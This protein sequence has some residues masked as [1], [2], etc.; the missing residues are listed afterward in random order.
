MGPA[1]EIPEF[2][3]IGAERGGE[4]ETKDVGGKKEKGGEEEEEREVKAPQVATEPAGSSKK[5]RRRK[6]RK[7]SSAGKGAVPLG[8]LKGPLKGTGGNSK[9]VPF[10]PVTRPPFQPNNEMLSNQE[11]A[12]G[13][14]GNKF[15]VNL[16]TTKER[17]L[18][19]RELT[20]TSDRGRWGQL[21][22]LQNLRKA[23]IVEVAATS[24]KISWDPTPLRPFKTCSYRICM[25]IGWKNGFTPV[26]EDTEKPFTTYCGVNLKPDTRYTFH[27]ASLCQSP[28]DSKFL[29]ARLCIPKS[30][31]RTKEVRTL[32]Q[33]Y[34]AAW[35]FEDEKEATREWRSY[36]GEYKMDHE[37]NDFKNAINKFVEVG[38]TDERCWS[39]LRCL[40]LTFPGV[41]PGETIQGGTAV[42]VELKE[43]RLFIFRAR[44]FHGWKVKE[45]D[46]VT[47]TIVRGEKGGIRDLFREAKKGFGRWREKRIEEAQVRGRELVEQVER[48]EVRLQGGKI[49]EQE[50]AIKM[51]LE[52]GEEGEEGNAPVDRGEGVYVKTEVTEPVD[53]DEPIIISTTTRYKSKPPTSRASLGVWDKKNTRVWS[54]EE[55]ESNVPLNKWHTISCKMVG[56]ATARGKIYVHVP[57][58][59][60]G[61]LFIDDVEV[62]WGGPTETERLVDRVVEACKIGHLEHSEMIRIGLCDGRDLSAVDWGGSSDPFAVVRVGEGRLEK[63][64]EREVL[65][66]SV[67]YANLFP[68]WNCNLISLAKPP[69]PPEVS[70]IDRRESEINKTDEAYKKQVDHALEWERKR[71]NEL[72][73][74][75]ASLREANKTASKEKKEIMDNFRSEA[76]NAELKADKKDPDKFYVKIVIYDHDL[77]GDDDYMGEVMITKR[78]LF[79]SAKHSHKVYFP[80]TGEIGEGRQ[81]RKATGKVAVIVRLHEWHDEGSRYGGIVKALME[82]SGKQRDKAIH[83]LMQTLN[84]EV[85]LKAE[86][87]RLIDVMQEPIVE[88]LVCHISD[89]R[90]CEGACLALMGLLGKKGPRMRKTWGFVLRRALQE[91]ILSVGGADACAEGVLAWDTGSS[92]LRRKA[93]CLELLGGLLDDNKSVCLDTV[94]RNPR[95][96]IAAVAGLQ[97]IEKEADLEGG[98]GDFDDDVQCARIAMAS[99]KLMMDIQYEDQLDDDV[100][101][102]LWRIRRHI[103]LEDGLWKR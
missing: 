67:A 95:I 71:F 37:A 80:V 5:K 57:I 69:P 52:G 79:N 6:K 77:V 68:V 76:G 24:I 16:M 35:F 23:D 103:P 63:V 4:N 8:P 54:Q 85:E 64:Q 73:R 29:G 58:G 59:F 7:S 62:I 83:W 33:E 94:K 65:R 40:K 89:S 31:L 1:T 91:R 75:G 39:G 90:R 92:K 3:A 25:K 18:V 13:I 43:D 102:V 101:K 44:V 74:G 46:I 70:A 81:K 42:D 55:S 32:P 60:Q 66:S 10:K 84:T 49:D 51:I 22:S 27:I 14:V 17:E 72:R 21:R 20:L 78:Q 53:D 9:L 93:A 34:E 11:K 100:I 26:V 2:I 88:E 38:H 87:K 86:L 61:D 47:K 12:C 15:G 19:K 50:M 41:E 28:V 98:G 99:R 36:T 45:Y 48:G 56:T 97:F 96:M 30:S 82:G